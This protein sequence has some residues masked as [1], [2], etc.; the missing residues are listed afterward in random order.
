[1]RRDVV[2]HALVQGTSV[3]TF[4]SS[5]AY[6]RCYRVL[7]SICQGMSPDEAFKQSAESIT[8]PITKTISKKGILEMYNSF[9]NAAKEEFKASTCRLRPLI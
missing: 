2:E 6:L 1:M 5:V 8:G 4:L 3:R 7:C 9:D